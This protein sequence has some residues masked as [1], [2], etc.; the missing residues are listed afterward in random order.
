M[1]RTLGELKELGKREGEIL[2]QG[3]FCCI[4]GKAL[5]ENNGMQA[6]FPGGYIV[7]ALRLLWEIHL[8]PEGGRLGEYER[9]W[10]DKCG[11]PAEMFKY[12]LEQLPEPTSSKW[13]VMYKVCSRLL[14]LLE[15]VAHGGSQFLAPEDRPSYLE[16]YLNVCRKLHCGSTDREREGTIQHPHKDKIQ[17]L[18]GIFRRLDVEAGM[19]LYI[20]VGHANY[21]DFYAFCK[22][23]SR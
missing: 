22:S 23:P 2:A 21:K 8:S 16:V 18:T 10:R 14:P 5:E 4:H 1:A 6:A 11:F 19:Y 3:E 7:D 15:P 9:I 17:T 13:E 12:S 20:D